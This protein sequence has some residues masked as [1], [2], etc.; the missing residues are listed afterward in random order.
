VGVGSGFAALGELDAGVKLTAKAAHACL[1]QLVNPTVQ[2]VIN[3]RQVQEA[4]LAQVQGGQWS[5]DSQIVMSRTWCTTGFA[6]VSQARG[7][8]LELK[9]AAKLPAVITDQNLGGLE[10]RLASSRA[11]TDFLLTVFG[12][13]STPVFGSVVRLK[14]SLWDKTTASGA[15]AGP[16]VSTRDRTPPTDTSTEVT[17][18]T[19]RLPCS[20]S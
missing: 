5:I 10:L 19:D 9:A 12:P 2:R 4:V 13:A 11:T 7:Q 8:S 15:S 20:I 6:A 14:R 3:Q 17:L 1:L 18:T 16:D